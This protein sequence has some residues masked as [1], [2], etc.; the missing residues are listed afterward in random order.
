MGTLMTQILLIVADA[1]SIFISPVPIAI[2]MN[3]LF[4][5]ELLSKRIFFTKE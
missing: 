2:G 4:F 1:C 3:V 5:I